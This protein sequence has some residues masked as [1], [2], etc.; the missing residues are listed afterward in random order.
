MCLLIVVMF[1]PIPVRALRRGELHQ[2]LQNW[3]RRGTKT[4]GATEAA[5]SAGSEPSEKVKQHSV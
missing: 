2:W 4:S 5:G 3:K 1:A